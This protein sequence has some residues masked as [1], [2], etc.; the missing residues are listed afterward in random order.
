M[1]LLLTIIIV[2]VI[3]NLAGSAIPTYRT[4][5]YYGPSWGVLIMIVLILYLLGYR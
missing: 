1:S 5:G 2:L 4:G 3:L